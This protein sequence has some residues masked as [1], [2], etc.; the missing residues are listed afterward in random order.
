MLLLSLL[1]YEFKHYST[2]TKQDKC[3]EMVYNVYVPSLN[4]FTSFLISLYQFIFVYRRTQSNLLAESWF[5][6]I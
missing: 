3:A 2:N 4:F 6:Y 5:T 1:L